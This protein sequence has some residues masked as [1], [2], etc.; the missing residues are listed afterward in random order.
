MLMFLFF[1]KFKFYLS[2]HRSDNQT[3]E[4][5]G[6]S[7][8][9]IPGSHCPGKKKYKIPPTFCLC[10][11]TSF[12]S[13]AGLCCNS[14]LIVSSMLPFVV[15]KLLACYLW[16]DWV[17]IPYENSPDAAGRWCAQQAIKPVSIYYRWCIKNIFFHHFFL[18]LPVGF[19][20][21]QPCR[22]AFSLDSSLY[23]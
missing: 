6:A 16:V 15:S 10:V 12:F 22:S 17:D 4:G 3:A 19:L 5:E 13:F 7:S 2:F 23:Q 8:W 11:R 14:H 1:E 18:L 9:R 21:Q 20:K